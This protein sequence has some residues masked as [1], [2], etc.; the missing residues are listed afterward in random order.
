MGNV[1]TEQVLGRVL[2]RTSNW[3]RLLHASTHGQWSWHQSHCF[4]CLHFL[5]AVYPLA[6]PSDGRI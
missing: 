4:R 5:M 1:P 3:P 6:H 2:K